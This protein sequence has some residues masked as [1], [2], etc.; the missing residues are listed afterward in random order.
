G[1]AR[2]RKAVRSALAETVPAMPVH[3]CFCFLN[4]ENQSG[5]SGLPLLRILR[6]EDFPLFYPRKLSKHLNRP[7]ELATQS[8]QEVA[9]L[10]AG[11]F[12]QA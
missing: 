1:L 8:R 9:E 4:P 2:Q 3:A 6:I 5:G 7:G 10:L 11:A 12:P